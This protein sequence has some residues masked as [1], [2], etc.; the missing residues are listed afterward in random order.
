[1][2]SMRM[3]TKTISVKLEAYERL[4]SAKRSPEESFSQVILRARWPH[5]T[6]TAADLLQIVRERGPSFP[7]EGLDRIE[8][9]KRTDTA[10][11]DKWQTPSSS[12]P[13]S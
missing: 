9:L 10:P 12:K 7:E 1:M 6:V 13:A 8:E 11:E 3:P 4:K 2:H 5:E